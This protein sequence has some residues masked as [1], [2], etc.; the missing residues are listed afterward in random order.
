MFKIRL[1]CL[2]AILKESENRDLAHLEP[3][4]AAGVPLVALARELPSGPLQLRLAERPEVWDQVER[5]VAWCH[6]N[7]VSIVFPGHGDYPTAFASLREPARVLFVRGRP[8]WKAGVGLS[9][10]GSREPTRFAFEWMDTHL[11]PVLRRQSVYTVSG[12]ARGVDQRAHALS[13][14]AGCPTVAFLPSGLAQIYPAD[15]ANWAHAIVEAGG[16]LVTEFP[17]WEPMRKAHFHRRN[18]L[19]ARMGAVCFVVEAGR[20]SGSL[21]TAR[22]AADAGIPVATLPAAAIEPKAMGSLDLLFDGAQVL[23]DGRD[24]SEFLFLNARPGGG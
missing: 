20:K 10:V 17:P 14:R 15:F 9:I 24:L 3:L 8:A 13:L 2:S 22:Y 23:R 16:A 21:I 19:I 7:G 1:A 12:G 6:D 5:T 4:L 18:R 11:S